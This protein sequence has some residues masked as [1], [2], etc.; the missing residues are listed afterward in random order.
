[1][2]QPHDFQ[3]ALKLSAQTVR[4]LTFLAHPKMITIGYLSMIFLGRFFGGVLSSALVPKS[5][6]RNGNTT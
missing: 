1:M 4:Q 2:E 6:S 3:A 5:P